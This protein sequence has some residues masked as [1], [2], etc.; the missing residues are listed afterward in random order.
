MGP[1]AGLDFRPEQMVAQRRRRRE[2]GTVGVVLFEFGQAVDEV[3]FA[4][5]V[6]Q[7][8]AEQLRPRA[9]GAV[10]VLEPAGHE[11]MLHLGHFPAHGDDEAINGAGIKDGVPGAAHALAHAA[12]PENR[13]SA[14][15]RADDGTRLENVDDVLAHAE[16]DSAGNAAGG[17]QRR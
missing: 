10:G 13:R 12:G 2:G 6:G 14:A 7:V 9:H 15:G 1:V 17:R 8:G 11:A 5:R 3:V 16:S 4:G